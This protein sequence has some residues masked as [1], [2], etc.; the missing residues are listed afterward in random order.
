MEKTYKSTMTSNSSGLAQQPRSSEEKSFYGTLA[1]IA[2]ITNDENW[3]IFDSIEDEGLFLL[4]SKIEPKVSGLPRGK[5]VDVENGVVVC[6]SFGFTPIVSLDK[7]KTLP[8]SEDMCL[9]DEFINRHSFSGGSYSITPAYEGVVVRAFK[10]NNTVYFSTHKKLNC[11]RSRWGGSDFFLDIYKRLGG[12]TG[13]ELFPGDVVTSPWCYNFLLV[14]EEL[15]YATK[16]HIGCGFIVDLGARRMWSYG[17]ECP[18]EDYGTEHITPFIPDAVED[19]LNFR[20]ETSPVTIRPKKLTLEEA[21]KFLVNGYGMWTDSSCKEDKIGEALIV[22]GYDEDGVVVDSVRVQSSAYNL[23]CQIRGDNPNIRH[24]FYQLINDALRYEKRDEL[25]RKYNFYAT[26]DGK[27]DL[28]KVFH[29]NHFIKLNMRNVDDRVFLVYVHFYDTLPHSQQA[30]SWSIWEDFKTD[31]ADVIK[32]FQNLSE[33]SSPTSYIRTEYGDME[34]ELSDRASA[35]LD[36]TKK[37]ALTRISKGKDRNRFGKKMS[38]DE[39]V[40]ANIYNLL[41]RENGPSLF[42]LIREMKRFLNM[43]NTE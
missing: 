35:I 26:V 3:K 19:V 39:L 31:R 16:Q 21:N 29:D 8:G 34:A 33:H 27:P 23:R 32:W 36:M 12:P 41:R 15:Q 9:M 28:I 14:D 25:L 42:K 18:F 22:Y 13:E 10:H 37:H 20:G 5:V 2:H 43:K 38:Q 40:K 1:D 7:L 4:H 17:E 30:K 24:R 6:D 11:S